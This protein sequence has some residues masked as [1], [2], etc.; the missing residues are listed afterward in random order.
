MYPPE[1]K[2]PDGKLRLLYESNPLAMI[3]EQAGG[4][5]T[6][7]KEDIMQI[8]PTSIHQTVPL[9]IGSPKDVDEAVSFNNGTHE[10]LK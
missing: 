5:A 1:V 6:T 2:K 8:Q 7:G 4:K 3:V 10:Y 9:F